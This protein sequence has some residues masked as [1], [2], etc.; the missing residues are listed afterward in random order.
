MERRPQSNERLSTWAEEDGR[1]ECRSAQMA[2]GAAQLFDKHCSAPFMAPCTGE[3]GPW[4]V[5]VLCHD[6]ACC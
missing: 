4:L 1:A 2:S 3:A 5:H 6:A